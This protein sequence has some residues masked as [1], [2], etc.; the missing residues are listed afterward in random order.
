MDKKFLDNI[1]KLNV[2]CIKISKESEIA[3]YYFK[4]CYLLV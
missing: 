1:N 2:K 4:N 3:I